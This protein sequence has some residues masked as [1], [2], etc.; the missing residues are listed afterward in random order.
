MGGVLASDTDTTEKT[1][2]KWAIDQIGDCLLQIMHA[3]AEADETAKIFMAKW[4][5]KDGFWHL[6]CAKGEEYNFAYVLPQPE[7]EL[8]QIVIPTLLQIGWV[9]SP[10]HFCMATETAREVV[11]EYIKMPVNSLHD[12]KFVKCTIGD[13]EYEALPATATKTMGFLY[14]VE[15]YVDDFMSLV[16]PV[17]Q[18]QL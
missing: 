1:T 16:I 11:K 17:S 3:F 14:M 12:H 6:D 18:E 8:I 4:D 9:E 13:K 15:V 2:P 7:E 5:I 10:P